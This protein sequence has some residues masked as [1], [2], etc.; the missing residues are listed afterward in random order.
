MPIADVGALDRALVVGSFLRKDHPLLA[1]RLRQ[2]AKKGAQISSLHSVDDDW[3]MPVAHRAVVAPSQ[4]PAILAQIVVAAAQ[5]AGKDPPA[6]LQGLETAAAAEVIAASLL[7]GE[8]RAILL[9]NYAIQHRDASQIVALAQALASITGATL[10]VCTEAANTVGGYVAGAVPQQGGLNAQAMLGVDGTESRRAYLLLH[11]EPEF[12]CANPV[13]ARAALEKADLVVVLSE[14]RTAMRYADVLLPIAPFTE[15]SGTFVNCEGRAQRFH[16]VVQPAGQARPGWK[17][18]R[19]LGTMLGLPGFE[20]DSAEQIRDAILGPSGTLEGKLSNATSVGLVAPPKPAGGV[21]RV[22]DIPIH[23]ADPLVRRSASLQAT[24][25]AKPPKARLHQTLLDQLGIAEGA[26]VKIR[27]GRG[28][29]VLATQ[30]DPA[31]PPGVV[32]IAAAH[33]STCGLEGLSGPVT[34][35]RA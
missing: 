26:Q 32:R 24:A 15:T 16:G 25:D 22:A 2:A 23:F 18:L 33:P 19:V 6:A 12:D 7:S 3:L 5:G 20:F 31:V 35:E 34:V 11:A 4:L 30:V 10:G 13:A 27:Q 1:H 29:A 9:G 28:E 14:F 8:R 21:E 17:V